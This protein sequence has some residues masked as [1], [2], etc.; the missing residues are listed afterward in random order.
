MVPPWSADGFFPGV[1]IVASRYGKMDGR[2]GSN[3]TDSFCQVGNYTGQ[4]LRGEKP[5]D[6]PVPQTTK[7]DLIVNPK[8]AKAHGIAFPL[9]LLTLADEGIE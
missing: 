1:A 3:F 6:L 5:V 4:I 8:T 7:V 2:Y 9:T